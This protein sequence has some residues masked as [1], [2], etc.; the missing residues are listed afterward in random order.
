MASNQSEPTPTN[1]TMMNTTSPAAQA[2]GLRRAGVT[3]AATITALTDAAYRPWI[4]IIGREPG[5]M[6]D[7][8][9][10][11]LSAPGTEVWIADLA[12]GPGEIPS[13]RTPGQAA[14][15]VVL[16]SE[17][18]HV[19]LHSV[20]VAPVA[21]GT[22]LG[23]RLMR[24]VDARALELGQTQ[25]RLYTHVKMARNIALYGRLGYQ[26]TDRRVDEGFSR[27]FMAKQIG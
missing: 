14:G 19:L 8:I 12:A 4:P 7:D 3:D 10:A 9:A 23:R 1:P 13:D 26:E 15:L 5:P 25:V 18:D 24:F 21:Q 2:A 11:L 20:A 22:G 16:M 27:V 17:P 6:G